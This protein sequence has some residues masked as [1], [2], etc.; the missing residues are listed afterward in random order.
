MD[1]DYGFTYSH[2]GI[3]V[4]GVDDGGDVVFVGDAMQEF[5]DDERRLWVEPRVRLVAK[6]VFRV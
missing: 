1:E 3:H 2:D 6:E 4:V 5:I